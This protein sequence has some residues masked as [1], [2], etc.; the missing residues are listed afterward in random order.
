MLNSIWDKIGIYLTFLTAFLWLLGTIR[1]GLGRTLGFLVALVPFTLCLCYFVGLTGAMLLLWTGFIGFGAYSFWSWDKERKENP[2]TP[3]QL[4]AERLR[5]EELKD[6]LAG[7]D[8]PKPYGG[9][10]WDDEYTID[11]LIYKES[12]GTYYINENSE[13]WEEDEE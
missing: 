8:E 13:E 6:I 5:Q 12:D 7:E 11:E 3:E 2:P 10:I 4:E 9:I 1:L